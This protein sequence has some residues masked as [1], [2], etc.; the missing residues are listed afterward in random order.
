M[1]AGAT[2]QKITKK[3]YRMENRETRN[4]CSDKVCGVVPDTLSHQGEAFSFLLYNGENSHDGVPI[5]KV[6]VDK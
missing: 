3:N 5:Y 4:I 1:R 6:L 2:S